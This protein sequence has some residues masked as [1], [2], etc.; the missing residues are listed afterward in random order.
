MSEYAQRAQRRWVRGVAAIRGT[1]ET[2]FLGD[3][4]A[5]GIEEVLDLRNYAEEAKRQRR[6]GG[7]RAALVIACG[8]L[9][10]ELLRRVR[11]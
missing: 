4:V 5:E 3:P 11:R 7:V 9:A 8:W 1:E 2:P 6:I 10:F